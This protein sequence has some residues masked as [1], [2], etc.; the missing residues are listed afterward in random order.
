[1][2]SFNALRSDQESLLFTDRGSRQFGIEQ[3]ALAHANINSLH[4]RKALQVTRNMLERT[5]KQECV[6]V[7]VERDYKIWL[8]PWNSHNSFLHIR[9]SMKSDPT[10]RAGATRS[11]VRKVAIAV[12]LG[13]TCCA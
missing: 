4:E 9:G 1:M 12:D 3:Y 13:E 2:L 10:P 11:E 8:G 5:M 7:R 6:H